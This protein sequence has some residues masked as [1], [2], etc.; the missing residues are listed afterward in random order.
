[1]VG[2]NMQR[3]RF[4]LFLALWERD[5]H[6]NFQSDKQHL[7]ALDGHGWHG[8]RYGELHTFRQW[9]LGGNILF[10]HGDGYRGIESDIGKRLRRER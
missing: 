9:D 1:M 2:R 6:G 8:N 10:L 5:S 4:V 3:N 7:H